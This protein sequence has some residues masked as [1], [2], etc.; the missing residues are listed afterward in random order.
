[1]RNIII[2]V[3]DIL[4]L[5]PE[6]EEVL[7][8]SIKNMSESLVHAAPETIGDKRLWQKLGEILTLYITHEDY[9][10]KEWCKQIIDIFQ[11]PNYGI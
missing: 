1:M 3:G 7:S 4:R 11:D 6:N 2:I 5:I 10:T 9:D 8:K